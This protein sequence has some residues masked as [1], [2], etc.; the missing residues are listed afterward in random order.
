MIF[1]KSET[2][3]WEPKG[4]VHDRGW[5]G[6]EGWWALLGRVQ[7][8]GEIGTFSWGAGESVMARE[9][10][11]N[12]VLGW[13]FSARLCRNDK[14]VG[15]RHSLETENSIKVAHSPYMQGVKTELASKIKLRCFSPEGT[16]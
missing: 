2:P 9:H 5:G 13:L 7:T 10:L 1:S 12:G 4:L 3:F 15:I 16:T 14:C 8:T 11:C 6:V